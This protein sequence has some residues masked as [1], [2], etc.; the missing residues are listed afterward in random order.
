MEITASAEDIEPFMSQS[1]AYR[2]NKSA[3]KNEMYTNGLVGIAKNTKRIVIP[4][5]LLLHQRTQ[6]RKESFQRTHHHTKQFCMVE[7]QKAHIGCGWL[8]KDGDVPVEVTAPTN[9][10]MTRAEIS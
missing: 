8:Q 10:M 6:N 3:R 7:H 9:G 5:W 2:C 4:G 1:D